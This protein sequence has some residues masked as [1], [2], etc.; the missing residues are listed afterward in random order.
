MRLPTLPYSVVLV[1]CLAALTATYWP[2]QG[3]EATESYYEVRIT[4]TPS[5]GFLQASNMAPGDQVTS[6]LDVQNEGNLDFNTTVSARQQSGDPNLYNDLDLKITD[7]QGIL[8]EGK[9]ADLQDFPL[10]TIVKAER[11]RLEFRATLPLASGNQLQGRTAT[12]AFDFTAIGHDEQLP[13]GD[14]CFEPPFSNR[15]FTLHQKSTVPIKF[16]LKNTLGGMETTDRPN[17]RLEVTGRGVGGGTVTYTFKQ[18][19]GT[20]KFDERVEEPHYLA[21]FSTF[22]YPVVTDATYQA[23]VYDGSKV[24]CGKS[25]TVL[26]QGNRSNAP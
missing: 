20:L 8:Y 10:G 19:D 11:K 4:T 17:V 25:F 14:D 16:H 12:T 5:S 15:N 3:T 13:P 21:R 26:K 2:I 18:S 22:D 9:F 24:M 7:G 1:L 6:F 23:I